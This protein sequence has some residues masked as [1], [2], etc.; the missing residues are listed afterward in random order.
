MSRVFCVLESNVLD[1][2]MTRVSTRVLE[3]SIMTLRARLGHQPSRRVQPTRHDGR[4]V[5]LA[6]LESVSLLTGTL[7]SD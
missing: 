7:D 4:L 3:Y 1:T 2:A 5:Q 6:G